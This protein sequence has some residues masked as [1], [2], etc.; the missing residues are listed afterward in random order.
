M[1]RPLARAP[2]AAA[3]DGVASAAVL[4]PPARLDAAPRAGDRVESAGA[5]PAEVAPVSLSRTPPRRRDRSAPASAHL[6][7]R[8]VAAD[9]AAPARLVPDGGVT[10]ER[11]VVTQ[12]GSPRQRPP[13]DHRDN[14]LQGSAAPTVNITIGRVEVRAVAAPP[15]RPRA[16]VRAPQPLGLDDYLKRRGAR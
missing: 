9:D 1:A 14:D 10:V 8:T 6:P 11:I 15:P 7:P 12:P 2:L 4:P 3:D 5:P 16:E 13:D